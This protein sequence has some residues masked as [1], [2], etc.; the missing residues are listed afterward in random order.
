MD[1]YIG[2]IEHAILHLLYAR[3]W[4]K[5]MRDMG[6][7]G[8]DEPFTRLMTQGMLLNHSYF[9]RTA[10]GGIDYF[11]PDDVEPV[12]DGE[13]R[14]VGGTL[15]S[16]GQPVEYG[17]TGTMSKSKK[18]GV[19][20]QGLIA[21]YGADTARMFVIFAGP[22]TD[23]ALWSD[24]GVLG[25]H[26]FLQQLWTYAQHRAAVLE[27]TPVAIDWRHAPPGLRKIRRELHMHLK[28]A[29]DDY[30]RI[31]YNNIVSAAMKML[32]ALE[33]RA[34]GGDASN[35]RACARGPVAAAARAQPG[36]AAHHPCALGAA[37]LRRPI[38]RHPR[39]TVAAGRCRRA[40]P[41]RDRT[42]TAGEREVARQVARACAIADSVAIEEAAIASP[43]V[44][45]HARAPRRAESSSFP[46]GWSMSSSRAAGPERSAASSVR[47]ESCC[48][49]RCSPGA[50][51]ICAAKRTMNSTPC[52]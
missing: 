9:R 1:Q 35:D 45:K 6:L 7:V 18:N 24:E 39:C 5:V 50:A 41:G 10:Q 52:S 3:F 25:P 8:F 32:N 36:R 31:K 37:G 2:G 33:D 27:R 13:G 28:Q 14:L 16:D 12:H 29:D 46:E 21:R 47:A 20:P 34:S 42:G 44:Q 51:F 40:R 30:Q 11:A 49:S 15:K 23:S 17:G 22:P 48:W 43:E 38:R 26:R 4:T 19:D